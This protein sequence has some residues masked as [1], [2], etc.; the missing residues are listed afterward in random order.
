MGKLL[1]RIV[2]YRLNS[3]LLQTGLDIIDN[4]LGFPVRHYKIDAIDRVIKHAQSAGGVELAVLIDIVNAFNSLPW[5]KIT[6]RA[7]LS[8]GLP[9]M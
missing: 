4:Q 9:C 5:N 6:I 7:L 1:E 2:A 8:R 3:Y